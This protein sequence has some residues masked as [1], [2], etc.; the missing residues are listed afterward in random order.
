MFFVGDALALLV[1]MHKMW[2]LVAVPFVAL[3]Q[4]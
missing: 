2:H 1:V 3:V 4:C